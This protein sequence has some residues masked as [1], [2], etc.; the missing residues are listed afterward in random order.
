MMAGPAIEAQHHAARCSPRRPGQG[1]PSRAQHRDR[2]RDRSRGARQQFAK[3]AC[4]V[5]T[6]DHEHVPTGHLRALT[7]AGVVVRPPGATLVHAKDKS[8]MRA[9]RPNSASRAHAGRWC[10]T[11]RRCREPSATT[12]AG[13]SSSETAARVGA[14][15]QK[16]AGR[17]YG[18]GGGRLARH[19]AR[20]LLAEERVELHPR[21][22]GAGRAQPL[23][24][25]R[26]LSAV[27]TGAGRERHLP[28]GKSAVAC[29]VRPG[30]AGAPRTRACRRPRRHRRLCRS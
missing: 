10:R 23:R 15:Q 9:G 30:S 3:R 13:Q 5:V 12:K 6:F 25:G 28:P 29:R 27:E 18:R 26:S 2:Q 11:P 14:R 19:V 7:D 8:L 24:P 1:R 20:A 16:C 4:D 21:A 17:R 22:G